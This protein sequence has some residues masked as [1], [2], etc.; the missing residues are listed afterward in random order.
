MINYYY[1]GSFKVI[2][3]NSS[4]DYLGLVFEWIRQILHTLCD[5]NQINKLI[6]IIITQLRVIIA[7]SRV[8]VIA[9]SR[10]IVIAL[11]RVIVIALAALDKV[12]F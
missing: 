7:L 12:Y 1:F 3:T 10:V 11:S 4:S 5:R 2:R 8:I 6:K 9:L